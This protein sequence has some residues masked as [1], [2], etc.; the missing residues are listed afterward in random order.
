MEIW[1][2][3]RNKVKGRDDGIACLPR[4]T[5]CSPVGRTYPLFGIVKM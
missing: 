2:S 4:I 1:E 5:L 3:Q